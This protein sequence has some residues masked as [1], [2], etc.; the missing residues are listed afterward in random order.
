MGAYGAARTAFESFYEATRRELWSTGIEVACVVPY[1][2]KQNME[3]DEE[4]VG[5]DD[6]TRT[7]LHEGIY[8]KLSR[9]VEA[10]LKT[11]TDAMILRVAQEILGVLQGK[12]SGRRVVWWKSRFHDFGNRYLPTRLQDLILYWK[13]KYRYRIL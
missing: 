7:I 12:K 3:E 5:K 10:I 9:E 4:F 8:R 6:R 11:L 2:L 1:C 13:L